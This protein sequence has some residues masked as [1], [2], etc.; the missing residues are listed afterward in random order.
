MT[1][2]CIIGVACGIFGILNVWQLVV[3]EHRL[4]TLEEK[5]ERLRWREY[6]DEKEDE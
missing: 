6:L 4:R 3:Y 2:V 5:V 1:G